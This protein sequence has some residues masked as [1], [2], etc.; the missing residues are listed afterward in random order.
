MAKLS[1]AQNTLLVIKSKI[2]FF[3]DFTN[4]E[5]ITLTRDVTFVKY[6]ENEIVFEQNSGG[7]DI[8]FVVQGSVD[9][10]LGKMVKRGGRA[11]YAEHVKLATLKRRSLFGEMSAIT[12][13]RRSA[14]CVSTID[15]TTLLR[16]K[17]VS[18]V[19]DSN[20]IILAILYYKFI[21]ILVQKLKILDEK[22]YG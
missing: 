12:G 21:D 20:K 10:L 4:N 15:G 1:N 5:V 22:V 6:N 2:P 18:K 7:K 3:D 14:R 16:F 11:K 13:E 9:V 19:E 17:V 8:Y